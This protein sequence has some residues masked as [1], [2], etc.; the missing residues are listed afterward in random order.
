MISRKQPASEMSICGGRGRLLINA[1]I[2]SCDC[3]IAGGGIL[4]FQDPILLEFAMKFSVRGILVLTLA[5]AVLFFLLATVR[6][7]IKAPPN[8]NCVSYGPL[9]SGEEVLVVHNRSDKVVANA[10]FIGYD[11]ESNTATIETSR[12]K[13]FAFRRSANYSLWLMHSDGTRFLCDL[14]PSCSIDE[15]EA[16]SDF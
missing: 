14:T 16:F 15:E 13:S 8:D 1:V 6:Y 12:L 3:S 7:D 4:V 10:T 5:V 11:L 9:G 2:P